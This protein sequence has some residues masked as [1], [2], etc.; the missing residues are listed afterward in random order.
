M[1][2]ARAGMARLP[3]D[4]ARLRTLA[5]VGPLATATKELQGNY[6]GTAPF[7]VSPLA[8][9]AALIEHKPRP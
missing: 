7:L 8:G 4:P 6:A 1:D 2:S 5:V 9:H 3:L